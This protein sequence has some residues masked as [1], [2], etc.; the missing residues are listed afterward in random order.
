MN[1]RVTKGHNDNDIKL[2]E[3]IEKVAEVAAATMGKEGNFTIIEENIGYPPKATKDGFYSIKSLR[4]KD[5]VVN[6]SAQLLISAAKKTAEEAGDGTT[7]CCVLTERLVSEGLKQIHAGRSRVDITRQIDKA[8]DMVCE[9]IKEFATPLKGKSMIEQVATVSANNREDIGSLVA[10]AYN[11]IKDTGKVTTTKT[12]ALKSY[13]ETTEGMTVERGYISPYFINN[14]KRY[15]CKFQNPYILLYDEAITKIDSILHI[16]EAVILAERPLVIVAKD[17]ANEAL[18]TL[19]QNKMQQG[20]PVAA[21]Y[22]PGFGSQSTIDHLEDIAMVTGGTVVSEF[23]G[24]KLDGVS[25]EMLGEADSIVITRNETTIVGGKG[26][27]KQVEDRLTFIR[28]E[29]ADITDSLTKEALERRIANIDGGV[30]I[31]YVGGSTDAEVGE[32]EDLIEDAIA[33]CKAAKELGVVAGGGSSLLM[34]RKTIYNQ[35]N[36]GLGGDIVYNALSAPMEQIMTNAG[37]TGKSIVEKVSESKLKNAGYDLIQG[38]IC[39]M[40]KSGILDV[41]KVEISALQNAASV[42][43]IILRGVITI[44]KIREQNEQQSTRN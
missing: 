41:A 4:F 16:L 12:K 42:A 29:I 20:F 22:A 40:I 18:A 24:Y 34:A 11:N 23:T 30:S 43:K 38:D 17:V 27:K 1:T 19:V 8:V 6:Q 13:C 44:T 32:K 36:L 37:L 3:G 7:T 2:K 33:A 25:L 35:E 31:I 39:D 26:D 5:P 9:N 10:E 14:D 28:S 21:I 15:E